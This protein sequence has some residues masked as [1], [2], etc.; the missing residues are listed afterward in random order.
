MTAMAT[1]NLPSDGHTAEWARLITQDFLGRRGCEEACRELA[2]LVSTEL[3]NDALRCSDG[4]IVLGIECAEDASLTIRASA[5]ETAPSTARSTGDDE[6]LS[7][8]ERLATRCDR[9]RDDE[10]GT[11]E[12]VCELRC[13]ADRLEIPSGHEPV[14]DP[15]A[16]AGPG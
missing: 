10:R 6:H 4:T 9:R 8:V 16:P 7:L 12:T 15:F 14:N 11:T 3:V 1:W 5:A 2:A 13:L